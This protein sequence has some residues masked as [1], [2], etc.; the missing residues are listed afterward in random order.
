MTTVREARLAG[1]GLGAVLV[2]GGVLG[3]GLSL[4]FWHGAAAEETVEMAYL[5]GL[6]HR[7]LGAPYPFALLAGLL[8]VP[9]HALWVVLRY[10]RAPAYD[11]FA[12]WAQTLFTSLGFLGTIIGISRAV[13]GLA[14]A[15]AA[16]EPG[17]LI[18]G[19]STAF[20]TTFLGLTAAILLLVLRKL[21]TLGAIS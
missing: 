13:A 15:M 3:L 9:L 17:D 1:A 19:L 10:G 6:V 21:F 12:A 18:S 8:A 20:D 7:S 11:G 4:G 2:A 14:P 5:P 16:G